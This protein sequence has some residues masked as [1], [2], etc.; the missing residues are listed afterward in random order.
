MCYPVCGSERVA[1]V[2]AADFLSRCPSGPLPYVQLPYNHKLIVLSASLNK[3]FTPSCGALAG[4][5]YSSLGP[6]QHTIETPGSKDPL[7]ITPN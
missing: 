5:R 7:I 1:H 2:V 3:I 4:T 6:P